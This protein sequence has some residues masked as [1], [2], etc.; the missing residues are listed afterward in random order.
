M[1]VLRRIGDARNQRLFEFLLSAT[2]IALMDS[3]ARSTFRGGW[4]EGEPKSCLV[5]ALRIVGVDGGDGAIGSGAGIYVW[6]G[7]AELRVIESV[8]GFEAQ[9]DTKALEL[10]VL[11]ERKIKI[12]DAR[13]TQH[14]A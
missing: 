13:R 8:E 5:L 4:L 11:E 12:S 14:V 1:T 3:R 2:Q 7:K 6:I 10:N 9:L